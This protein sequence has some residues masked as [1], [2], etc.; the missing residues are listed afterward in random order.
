MKRFIII[1]GTLL[2]LSSILAEGAR[3]L[4]IT[5]DNFYNAIQP[6]ADWKTKKGVLA[7]V[8][9][10]SVTGSTN[11]QIKNYIVNAYNTWNPRPEYV[12]LVGSPDALP[13]FPLGSGGTDSPYADIVGDYKEEVSIGRFFTRN[14]IECG[15]MVAKSINYEKNPPTE[16]WFLKGTTIVREDAPPDQYYQA[17]CRYIRNLMLASGYIQIDSFLSTAG[18]N[19]SDVMNAINNGRTYV[20]YRGQALVQWWSPFH[21]VIP[22]NL[23][24]GFK[25]PVV[26]SG[27]CNTVTLNPLYYDYLGDKFLRAGTVNNP[28]GAVGYFGTTLEASGI[29][30]Y[31]SVVT[32]GV[33]NALFNLGM[34]KMGDAAKKQN[35][36]FMTNIPIIKFVIKNGIFSVTQNLISGLQFH[37][38][39]R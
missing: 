31:R 38:K 34:Y 28:K 35:G 15:I 24:N 23:T 10:L 17:D 21:Q 4:I 20:V 14:V 12:L 16:D 7:K 19:S 18:N 5:H 1:V 22:E 37:S 25:L 33:F 36:I 2:C 13:S 6:L 29:S 26:V 39:W 30:Q 32:R 9:P 8:V 11:T 3:Y 27:S